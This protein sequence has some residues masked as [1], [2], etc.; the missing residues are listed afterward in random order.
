MDEDDSRH[1]DPEILDLMESESRRGRRPSNPE[2]R[3][4]QRQL[5]SDLLRAKD[6]RDQRAFS[7]A[8]RR[9]GIREGSEPW[10]NAWKVFWS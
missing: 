5:I 4:R 3:R 2:H 9:V 1:L 10:K 8:L 6:N 7:E